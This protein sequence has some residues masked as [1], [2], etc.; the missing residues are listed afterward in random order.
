M[1]LEN[2]KPKIRH[3]SEMKEVL[4]DQKWAE[5]ASDLELYYMYRDLAENPE[6]S[7]KIKADSNLGIW[8]NRSF[9]FLFWYA[10]SP[11]HRPLA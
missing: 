2:L 10:D 5:N 9:I 6:D 3:L 7:Q 8:S 1:N 4:F 11:D